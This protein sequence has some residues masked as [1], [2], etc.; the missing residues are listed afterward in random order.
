MEHLTEIA[1]AA[2]AISQVVTVALVCWRAMRAVRDATELAERLVLLALSENP[3]EF[4]A[5]TRRLEEGRRALRIAKDEKPRERPAPKP[6]PLWPPRG[7][8]ER[9]TPTGG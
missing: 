7:P 9:S 2:V 6:D 5:A 3:G 8:P 1:L 4:V